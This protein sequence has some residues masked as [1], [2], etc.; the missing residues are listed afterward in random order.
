MRLNVEFL[1]GNRVG[2]SFELLPSQIDKSLA[3][4]HVCELESVRF[5]LKSDKR[6]ENV[7]LHAAGYDLKSEYTESTDQSHCFKWVPRYNHYHKYYEQL[8]LN[9]FGFAEL[10]VSY[11]LPG[12]NQQKYV[13]YQPLEV[14]ATKMT[15]KQSEA[16]L[17]FILDNRHDH[18][19]NAISPVNLQANQV[20]KGE[21]P[22][23]LLTMLEKTVVDAYDLCRPIIKKPMTHLRNRLKLL[24]GADCEVSDD[25]GMGWMLDN[26]SVLHSVSDS[27]EALLEYKGKWYGAAELLSSTAHESTNIYENQLIHLFLSRIHRQADRIINGLFEQ[28]AKI[29]P[30][31]GP[32]DGYFSFF[33]MMKKSTGRTTHS[34]I[35]RAQKCIKKI[36]ELLLILRHKIPAEP[37]RASDVHLTERM[38]LNKSYFRLFGL[39][40]SWFREREID[41]NQHNFLASINS[42]PMLFE[43]YCCLSLN[44]YLCSHG[45]DDNQGKELFSGLINGYKMHLH[46][47]PTYW[48]SGHLFGK[49]DKYVNTDLQR[50][51][52]A[53]EDFPG[54]VRKGPNARRTPDFVIEVENRQSLGDQSSS[55][56]VLDAKYMLKTKVFEEELHK[57]TMKYVHGI[58]SS[59]GQSV[60]NTMILLFPESD[61]KRPGRYLSYH[62]SPYDING[63]NPVFPVLGSQAMEIDSSGKEEGLYNL[64]DRLISQLYL[65]NNLT[66]LVVNINDVPELVAA[67]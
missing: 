46:Y 48:K 56:I 1:G 19:L 7:V 5:T 24:Y 31:K 26:L 50:V 3:E 2:Q 21:R 35:F 11:T 12:E 33:S 63:T 59:Q 17:N 61:L 65:N 53:T 8:F 41:W 4:E 57:C 18:S 45:K 6:L 47:E 55:L 66:P 39:M 54:M 20:E 29:N 13:T 16:M 38:R 58:H 44:K 23:E 60:V 36:E 52:K 49:G 28:E 14:M 27:D 67:V 34:Q 64:L 51:K 43:L 32:P 10:V 40:Q 42:T 25:Q 22:E 62:A 15:A 37:W 30:T 9:F